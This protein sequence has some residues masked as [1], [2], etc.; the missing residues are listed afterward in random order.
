VPLIP[1][2]WIGKIIIAVLVAAAEVIVGEA[3]RRKR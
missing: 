2:S 3:T 1:K